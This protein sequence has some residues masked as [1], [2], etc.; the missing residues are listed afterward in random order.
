MIPV[1]IL[2]G[3]GTEKDVSNQ[4]QSI[5]EKGIPLDPELYVERELLGF[6]AQLEGLSR[7]T[8]QPNDTA[9]V[10]GQVTRN[11]PWEAYLAV[12]V[13]CAMQ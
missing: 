4:I 6:Y 5:L 13:I 11:A 3:I 10:S 7:N 12:V 8:S 9:L 1:A 2:W